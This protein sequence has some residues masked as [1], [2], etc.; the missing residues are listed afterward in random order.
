MLEYR[1]YLLIAKKI[2]K[3]N[4][5]RITNDLLTDVVTALVKADREYSVNVCNGNGS[6][7]GF[8]KTMARFAMYEHFKFKNKTNKI[9]SKISKFPIKEKNEQNKNDFQINRK[10]MLEKITGSHYLSEIQKNSIIDYYYNDLTLV[11]IG[12]KLNTSHQ[13]IAIHIKKALVK[14]KTV[15]KEYEY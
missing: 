5:A 14:L 15:L 8:R 12:Q 13:N 7:E 3:K 10:E 6:L 11:E 4:K 9:I 1:E 2:I